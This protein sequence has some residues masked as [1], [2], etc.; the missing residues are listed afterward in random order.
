MGAYYAYDP[1]DSPKEHYSQQVRRSDMRDNTRR[2]RPDRP[3][4]E[5]GHCE[6]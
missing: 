6:T 1:A 2:G 5:S 4:S 3:L